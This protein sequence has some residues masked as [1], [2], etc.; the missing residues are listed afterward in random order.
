MEQLIGRTTGPQIDVAV[1]LA[2]TPCHALV[3]ANQLENALLNLC[4]NAR[5]AMP[6]GGQLTIRTFQCAL[7]AQAA[8]AGD[9]PAG[10][11]VLLSV[12]DT[13]SGMTPEVVA[14]AFD[15]FFTTKP[16]GTGTGLGLSMVYGFVRQSGGM[17]TIESAP[18][19]G[20]TVRVY[21][22][23]HL[24]E[25]DGLEQPV[26]RPGAAPPLASGETV[27]LVDDEPT[28][29]MLIAEVLEESGYRVIEASDGA[30]GMK[31]LQSD[32]GID[33]LVTDVGLPGG[34]NGRQLADAARQIRIGLPVLFIT[35]FSDKAAVG[36]GDLEPGMQV[37]TKPFPMATL[38]RRVEALIAEN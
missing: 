37:L 33:L 13:G 4:I 30:A 35:G 5:H 10:Q 19:A 7:D 14:R 24:G 20:T 32:A 34:M 2:D 3:D 18:S 21:L 31:V 15:P 36:G 16:I 11:Y 25:A 27:L 22:P 17:V 38:A 9:L 28:L 6:D 12:S 8:R 1:V 29:R 23:S 26:I